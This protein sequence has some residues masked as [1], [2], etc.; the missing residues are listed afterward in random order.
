[1]RPFNT[2]GERHRAGPVDNFASDGEP[3]LGV[4]AL[5]NIFPAILTRSA[6]NS[7]A[8]KWAIWA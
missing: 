4:Y 5:S 1:M 7:G 2:I 3:G 6:K 8:V